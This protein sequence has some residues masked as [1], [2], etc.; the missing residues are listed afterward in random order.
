MGLTSVTFVGN[1]LVLKLKSWDLWFSYVSPTMDHKNFWMLVQT[2]K[3]D[4]LIPRPNLSRGWLNVLLAQASLRNCLAPI[5]NQVAALSKSNYLNIEI[6][7]ME[8][9]KAVCRCS[10]VVISWIIQALQD[11]ITKGL[12]TAKGGRE[13]VTMWPI[14]IQT[15]SIFSNL[16]K[17][18][19]LVSAWARQRCC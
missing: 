12:S 11:T 9:G 19:I 1:I 14:K 13:R 8:L 2:T 7:C 15:V 6:C 3:Q 5:S 10:L 4:S 17:N 16:L 18:R